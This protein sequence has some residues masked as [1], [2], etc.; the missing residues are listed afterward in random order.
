M[1]VF[2][3]QERPVKILLTQKSRSINL[4]VMHRF[5]S[6]KLNDEYHF[7]TNL[8]ID[9]IQ[10]HFGKSLSLNTLAGVARFSRF[11]FHRI[12]RT[13][14]GETTNAFLKRIRL[15]KATNQLILEK[16]KSIT[17]IAL[18]CG[19]SSSQNFAK[20]FKAYYG[21]TPSDHRAEFNWNRLLKKIKNP[22]D[23]DL[24]QHYQV[25]RN[26]SIAKILDRKIPSQVSVKALPACRVAYLRCKPP[27]TPDLIRGTFIRLTNWA[28]AKGI[29]TRDT[30]FLGVHWNSPDITPREKM[31][32]DA[33]IAVPADVKPDRCVNV[34]TLAAGKFAV[35]R[36]DVEE[37]GTE[38]EWVSL[39]FNWLA[40]SNYM[41][42]DRPAY[43]IYYNNPHQHP[44][45]RVVLDICMPVRPLE[46]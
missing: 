46:Q 16:N 45:R 4:S 25:H 33:C 38:E 24:A 13:V 28:L 5:F 22:E 12:F 43:E 10:S 37:G 26:I 21:I 32:Y 19:F 31:I 8:A 42:D 6:K 14:T 2:L 36:C 20:C 44:Q 9:Y 17:E 15:E 11:H 35:Q 7:R 34:R 23:S 39:V 30:L 40:R 1:S 41:P 29:I 18:D 27:F 3:T